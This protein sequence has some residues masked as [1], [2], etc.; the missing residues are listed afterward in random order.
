MAA[1]GVADTY[2]TE[3]TAKGFTSADNSDLQ[4]L[5]KTFVIGLQNKSLEAGSRDIAQENRVEKGNEIYDLLENQL[6]VAGKNYWR[7]RSAA[8]YNDYFIYNNASGSN[9]IKMVEGDVPAAT[10]LNIE[11]PSAVHITPTS[12]IKI[13]VSGAAL[14]FY[15][16]LTQGGLP[17]GQVY[18]VPVSAVTL[19]PEE[20]SVL[21]GYTGSPMF[22]TVRNAGTETAHYKLTVNHLT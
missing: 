1:H 19:S 20:F 11:A 6:C 4:G 15:G 12:T 10:T 5:I 16:S 7:T 2:Q 21:T 17:V 8:K 22:L 9:G 3:L 13:E 18:E 14:Q